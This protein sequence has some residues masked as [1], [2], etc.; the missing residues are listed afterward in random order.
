VNGGPI[1]LHPRRN[2]SPVRMIR[3]MDAGKLL[4]GKLENKAWVGDW[5]KVAARIY[6]RDF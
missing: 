2:A 5:L 1:Q 3:L 6:M 4:F